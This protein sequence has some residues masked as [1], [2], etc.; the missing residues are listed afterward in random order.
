MT[1]RCR[2][3]P[4]GRGPLFGNV[5]RT[6]TLAL[7]M[8]LLAG[9]AF[10]SREQHLVIRNRSDDIKTYDGSGGYASS[11]L[12]RIGAQNSFL[13]TDGEVMIRGF[14][15]PS[16]SKSL[17][18]G[19]YFLPLFPLFW[20]E[21]KQY[22]TSLSIRNESPATIIRLTR[23]TDAMGEAPDSLI[24]R[25]G[26]YPHAFDSEVASYDPDSGGVE[27]PPGEKVW[28]VTREKEALLVEIDYG[29][30]KVFTFKRSGSFEWWFLTV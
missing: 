9:C 26:R 21:G 10:L 14:S 12:A 3:I 5:L 30:R 7:S 22:Q 4:A 24:L 13:F 1:W 16:Y 28:I 23:I 29:V 8:W 27:I 20:G 11:S 18:I 25:R 15:N 19:I 17:A 2:T 6:T